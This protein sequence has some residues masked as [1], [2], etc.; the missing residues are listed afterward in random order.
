PNLTLASHLMGLRTVGATPR[1]D[2]VMESSKAE[3]GG[4]VTEGQTRGTRDHRSLPL[5]G[6][7]ALL[8]LE[9]QQAS[10]DRAGR[11]WEQTSLSVQAYEQARLR[12]DSAEKNLERIRYELEKCEIRAPF[13]GVISGRYVEKGQVIKEDDRKTLFQVTALGPLL[14]RVYVPEWALF[15]LKV[16]QRAGVDLTGAGAAG[17]MGASA[18]P[19]AGAGADGAARAIDARVRWIND[20]LDA[21]SGSDEVL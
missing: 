4:R 9:K 21:A 16:G 2:A 11:H 10:F 17:A 15:G 20:V 19:R 14:A 5:R 18:P 12:R 7:T 3:R 6:T 13:D 1:R 8:E